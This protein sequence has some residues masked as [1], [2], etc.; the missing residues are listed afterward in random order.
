MFFGTVEDENG[1]LVATARYNKKTKIKEPRDIVELN[2]Q[3]WNSSKDRFELWKEPS[4]LW[5][6]MFDKYGFKYE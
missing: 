2:H 1:D 5:K 4:D 6:K 3:W